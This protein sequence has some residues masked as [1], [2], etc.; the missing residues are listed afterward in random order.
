MPLAQENTPFVI[1]ADVGGTYSRVACFGLDGTLLGSATG[2]GGSPFHNTDA[3]ANVADATERALGAGG[4]D[5]AGAIGLVAGLANIS[6]PGS[7]QG[8]GNND[9]AEEFFAIPS[10]SCDRI[11]VNDA[12]VA[13][14]GA[15]LGRPG[16]MVVAGTGSMILAIDEDGTEVESGQFQHYAGAAR[17]LVFETMQLILVG[18]AGPDDDALVDAVL[19]YWDAA[20]VPELR[21]ALLDLGATDPIE[22]RHRYGRLA[23]T[24]TAAAETS[25][26]A[27]RA[28]RDLTDK[29]AR[30][31][32]LLLP[33]VGDEETQVAVTGSLAMTPAFTS[34]LDAALHEE[35]AACATLVPTALDALR[36]AALMAYQRVGVPVGPGVVGRLRESQ[37]DVEIR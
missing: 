31:I 12:V 34:R 25:P 16:V 37:V 27:D 14:R 22:V 36:G 26:L 6:R 28:L 33:F 18:A 29:T 2:K 23:P 32:R 13:H 4:L 3:A 30:G 17:H 21:R 1:A 24:V 19:K 7:N 9:W 8:D 20:D 10:L 15:L 5:A 11:I 35:P